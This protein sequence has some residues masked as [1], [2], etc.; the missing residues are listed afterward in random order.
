MQ[1]T[2]HQELR[3][4]SSLAIAATR[5]VFGLVASRAAA[6][7]ACLCRLFG[8]RSSTRPAHGL[9]A[10]VRF[11]DR[12]LIYKRGFEVAPL[13]VVDLVLEFAERVSHGDLVVRRRV[14]LTALTEGPPSASKIAR[15][16]LC[17]YT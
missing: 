6:R 16:P 9:T 8:S 2:A 13:G 11:W 4:P 3:W 14:R 17:V 5:N 10:H 7:T 12:Q 1:F 15:H